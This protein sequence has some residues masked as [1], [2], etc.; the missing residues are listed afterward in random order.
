MNTFYT[1]D[2][3]STMINPQITGYSTL[4]NIGRYTFQINYT[5]AIN[6]TL[7]FPPSTKP[8]DRF[9]FVESFIDGVGT[10]DQCFVG[11]TNVNPNL[12][13]IEVTSSDS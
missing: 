2:P 3:L 7:M 12:I 6:I 9:I 4:G 5:T 1:D 10:V 11:I 8:V 13:A